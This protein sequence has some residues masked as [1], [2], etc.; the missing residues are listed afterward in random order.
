M[1]KQ[2]RNIYAGGNTAKGYQHFYDSVLKGLDRVLILIGGTEQE[3]SRLIATIG[4]EMSNRCLD[5]EWI[6]SPF[7]NDEYD[8][9]MIPGLKTGV[10]NGNYPRSIHPKAPGVIETFVDLTPAILTEKLQGQKTRI[11]ELHEQI[12]QS[13]QKAYDSF[14]QALQIHDEWEYFYINALD[15]KKA[16]DVTEELGHMLLGEHSLPKKGRSRHMYFGAAT[17]KGPVDHIQSLTA[18][19]EKRYFIKGR[20][21]S[22]K[23]TMLKKLAA[24]AEQKG[25]DVEVYHCGFDPNSL[26]MLVIPERSVAIFDSTAPH[27]YFPSRVGDEIVD[28]YERTI[29][30]GTDEKFAVELAE[31]KERYSAKMK[32]GTG[33]LAEAKGMRD[34]LFAIYSQATDPKLLE[35]IVHHTLAECIR[36]AEAATTE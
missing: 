6:H 15:R 32:E 33:Y 34:Q 25:Y 22:G 12:A 1:G 19:L 2:E 13:C 17:P 28:M 27:E 21:G 35:T 29:E 30:P 3:I 10:V 14:A 26:D 18:N 36:M 16:N 7:V 5:V 9:V 11:V 24:E 31:I 4:K 8:G 23:S 20:P